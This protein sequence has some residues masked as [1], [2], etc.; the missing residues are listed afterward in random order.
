MILTFSEL[1]GLILVLFPVLL[2]LTCVLF[3]GIGYFRDQFHVS[4]RKR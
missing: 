4:N 1:L 3:D 2:Y